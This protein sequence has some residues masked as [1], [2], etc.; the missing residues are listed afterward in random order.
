MKQMYL[1]WD[2]RKLYEVIYNQSYNYIDDR[3]YNYKTSYIED[4][5]EI[6]DGK[7]LLDFILIVLKREKNCNHICFI[8]DM[9]YINA[10]TD[11]GLGSEYKIYIKEIVE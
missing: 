8:D 1:E 3:D 9:L 5:K 2:D 11:G 4:K 6:M 7:K 10:L